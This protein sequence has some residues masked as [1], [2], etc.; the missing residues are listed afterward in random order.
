[1]VAFLLITIL[2]ALVFIGVAVASSRMEAKR[3]KQTGNP[4][5]WLGISALDTVAAVGASSLA[6][7][8][9]P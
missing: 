3:M 8:L 1:V 7:S 9:L 2:R 4:V 6:G 5:R